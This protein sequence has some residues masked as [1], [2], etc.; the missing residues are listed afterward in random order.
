MRVGNTVI[1]RN[2]FR[3][4]GGRQEKPGSELTITALSGGHFG[5]QNYLHAR[6]L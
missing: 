4:V 6:H 5:A 3:I 2:V 1:V